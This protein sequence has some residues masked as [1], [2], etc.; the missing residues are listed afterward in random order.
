MC[1]YLGRVYKP[2]V[3]RNR[4]FS[5]MAGIAPVGYVTGGLHAAALVHHI[6]WLFGSMAL[7]TILL[8]F[9]ALKAAPTERAMV[10]FE[11]MTGSSGHPKRKFDFLGAAL[12]I[13][14]CG[15][16]IFGLTQGSSANWEPYT[17]VTVI[18]GVII[19]FIFIQVER[20]VREPLVPPHLW[21]IHLFGPMIGCYFMCYGSFAAAQLYAIRFWEDIQGRNPLQSALM[22]IPNA[23]IG[24]TAAFL[25][26]RLFHILDGHYILGASCVAA[27]LMPFFFLLNHPSTNYF[28]F[29][30]W[31]IALSTFSPDLS[32]AACSL[33]ISNSV[34]R[35]YQGVAS[36]ILI[37]MQ[38][39]SSALLTSLAETVGTAVEE[40]QYVVLT[41][42]KQYR[43]V[44][45][46][47]TS[48]MGP[49]H[50]VVH[51]DG[52][53]LNK[54]HAIWLF[55]LGG[56]LLSLAICVLFLRI[57][58]GEADGDHHED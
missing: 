56:A 42:P 50:H 7:A 57:P 12:A 28:I 6:P 19:L 2:G 48:W 37:T 3:R 8:F 51:G 35:R 20:R 1:S 43:E 18:L 31:G 21:R 46:Y 10:R 29:S 54:L 34:S 45:Q 22:M 14:G 38:N 11:R 32:F 36:S 40:K 53:T 25:V 58:K 13:A 52:V 44:G 39:L 47:N 24:I 27:M 5:I 30:M 4:V 17:Y 49:G 23:V 15:L 26:A 41:V 16:V 9:A 33:F 55:C